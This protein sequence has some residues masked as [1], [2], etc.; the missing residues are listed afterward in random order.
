MSFTPA[1]VW[2]LFVDAMRQ[3]PDSAVLTDSE[4]VALMKSHVA[5]TGTY[6]TA[7]ST[8]SC[9]TALSSG[10]CWSGSAAFSVGQLETAQDT[11]LNVRSRL[12][13]LFFTRLKSLRIVA[14]PPRW[15]AS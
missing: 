3:A 2:V 5:W 11:S 10:L 13:I 6:A 8:I 14:G 15:L 12:V 7:R 1:R 9:M 4:A